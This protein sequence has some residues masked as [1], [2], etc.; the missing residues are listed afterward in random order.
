MKKLRRNLVAIVLCAIMFTVIGGIYL[1]EKNRQR[2]DNAVYQQVIPE[3]EK[4]QQ[5]LQRQKEELIARREQARENYNAAAQAYL[6]GIAFFGDSLVSDTN[7]GGM[8]FRSTI[9]S[10]VRSN[11]CTTTTAYINTSAKVDYSSVE[12]FLPVI[13]MGDNNTPL[14]DT[15]A[16]LSKQ[17][18]YI[19]DHDRYIVVGPTT[20]TREGMAYFEYV[21]TQAYGD[22]F[23]NIREYMSTNGL[24]SLELEITND[25]KAA[26][27]QGRIPPSFLKSDGIHLN[28]NGTR[29]LSYLTFERMTDLGYFEEIIEAKQLYSEAEEEAR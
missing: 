29:L 2:F 22:K 25:D 5:E 9:S 28:D 18:Q 14:G 6:P 21:M 19:G 15:D 26:M 7:G 27:N 10:L 13:F 17:A 24:A 12:S 23:V 8:D 3:F 16:L 4:Q 20:G 11:V 1:Y